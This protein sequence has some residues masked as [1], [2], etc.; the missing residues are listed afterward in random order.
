MTV[1]QSTKN[2]FQFLLNKS[3]LSMAL[4][5]M[6]VECEQFIYLST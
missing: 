3:V 1:E 4:S 2:Y 5:A 6:M